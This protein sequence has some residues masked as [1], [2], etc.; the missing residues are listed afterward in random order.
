MLGLKGT[1]PR[2][3]PN[4]D[5]RNFAS[6]VDTV[7]IRPS[8]IQTLDEAEEAP[9]DDKGQRVSAHYVVGRDGA[10]VQMLD[11]QLDCLA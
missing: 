6:K 9:I 8:N 1:R 11:E 2:R 4:W 5:V 7:V 10:L 3:S